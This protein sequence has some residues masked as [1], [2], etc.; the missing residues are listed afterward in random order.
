MSEVRECVR[1]GEG[2]SAMTEMLFARARCDIDFH[3]IR[4]L[5]GDHLFLCAVELC[6]VMLRKPLLTY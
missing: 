2:P 5:I 1:G 4:V 6:Y 3:P